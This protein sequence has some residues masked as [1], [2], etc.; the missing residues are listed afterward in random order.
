[1]SRI[2]DV[3]EYFNGS[4]PKFAGELS[5]IQLIQALN[6]Y[7]QNRVD[8][9]AE[10]YASDFFKKKLKITN[11]DNFVKSTSPTFGFLCRLLMNGAALSEKDQNWFEEQINKVKQSSVEKK[12]VT[13]TPKTQTPTLNIQDRIKE[14]ASE[15]IAELEGFVDDLI[16]SDFKISLNPY[17]MMHGMDIKSVHVR[18][19]L[20]H[21]KNRRVEYDEVLNTDDK[22]LKE[23]YSNFTKPQLKKLIAL[24]DQIILD[25]NKISGESVKTRKPR[26]VKK[27]TPEQ[28]VTKVNVCLEFDEL[29]LKSIDTKSIIGATQLWVYNTKTRKLGVYHSEDAGGFS[30]KGSTLQNFNESKSVQKKL[31]KPEVILPEVLNAGKVTIRNLMTGIRAVESLLTGRLNSDTILLRIVK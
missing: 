21:F 29:G 3:N 7:T 9:D 11:M 20:T 16:L 14:K 25:C 10:K 30:V 19:I 24:F 17:G 5:K 4:E 15:C 1:M 13:D 28:L 27:K 12:V 26:K 2:T 18:H 6:W 22:D 23:G 31:R 8:K